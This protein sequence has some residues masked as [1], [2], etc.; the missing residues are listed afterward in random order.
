LD[1]ENSNPASSEAGFVPV[2][3]VAGTKASEVPGA[4]VVRPHLEFKHKVAELLAGSGPKVRDAVV[5]SLVDVQMARRQKAVLSIIEKIDGKD[6]ELQKGMKAGQ[7]V[8]GPD[9]K[10]LPPT[11]TKEQLESNKKLREEVSKMENALSA[12]LDKNDWNKLFELTG[13]QKG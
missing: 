4:K 2:S 1:N 6:R 10:P 11:F 8:F 13:E 3:Q 12:A 7:V 9:E 5:S